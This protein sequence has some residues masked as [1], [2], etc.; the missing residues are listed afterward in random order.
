[1][2]ADSPEP[3]THRQAAKDAKEPPR[4]IDEIA[5]R[6]IGAAIE[7]HRHLGPGFYERM[8]EEALVIELGLRGIL[9]ERQVPIPITYK[10]EPIGSAHLDLLVEGEVVVELKAVEALHRVHTA[11][12]ISYLQA[13]AFPLG[14]LL[15]F[16][17]AALKEGGIRRV[18]GSP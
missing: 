10:N 13:G 16:N 3:R 18:I 11:Q 12:V 4:H 7:V 14:L 2:N 5:H 9:V 17:V 1:M 6:I 8:Y 15:N